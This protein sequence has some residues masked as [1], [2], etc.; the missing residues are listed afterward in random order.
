M[1]REIAQQRIK[2][3]ARQSVKAYDNGQGSLPCKASSLRRGAV[4]RAN[5]LLHPQKKDKRP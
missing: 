3:A 1:R 2:Q 4:D 5:P